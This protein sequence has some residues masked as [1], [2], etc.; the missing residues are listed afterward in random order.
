M[1]KE[2]AR[3][4]HHQVWT[5]HFVVLPCSPADA[6]LQIPRFL[7]SSVVTDTVMGLR[8]ILV[9]C[10]VIQNCSCRYLCGA[11]GNLPLHRGHQEVQASAQ[12]IHTASCSHLS[13]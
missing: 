1:S 5:F 7:A 12:D 6:P 11:A 9:G 8:A 4:R 13:S 3:P 10:V 2:D